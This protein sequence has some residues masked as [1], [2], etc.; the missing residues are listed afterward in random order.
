MDCGELIVVDG[1]D[2]REANDLWEICWCRIGY[3]SPDCHSQGL[4]GQRTFC[5]RDLGDLLERTG[6][7]VET[8]SM[9]CFTATCPECWSVESE[10]RAQT[11]KREADSNDE[12]GSCEVAWSISLDL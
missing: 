8:T 10:W 5:A 11:R 7:L 9:R 4:F 12:A 6:W 2:P 3:F 1:R